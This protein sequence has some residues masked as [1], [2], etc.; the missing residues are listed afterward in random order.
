V[1]DALGEPLGF[2]T[3]SAEAFGVLVSPSGIHAAAVARLA[4]Y[5]AIAERVG[6]R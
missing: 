6:G 1:S 2:N 5:A 4:S 3:P